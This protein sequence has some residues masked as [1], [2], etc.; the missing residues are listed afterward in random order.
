MP[1]IPPALLKALRA[2]RPRFVF[3]WPCRGHLRVRA[4]GGCGDGLRLG[5]CRDLPALLAELKSAGIFAYGGPRRGPA[6]QAFREAYRA[7]W[8]RDPRPYPAAQRAILSRLGW[9][10]GPQRLEHHELGAE[11]VGTPPFRN[12]L[13]ETLNHLELALGYAQPGSR[14]RRRLLRLR[15]RLGRHL[16]IPASPPVCGVQAEWRRHPVAAFNYRAAQRVLD[17]ADA[18]AAI[19]GQPLAA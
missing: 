2:C 4:W 19:L 6:F 12:V 3:V 15:G 9:T 13:V 14:T 1:L 18:R 10:V 7:A 5:R 11:M 16:R 8:T 17:L